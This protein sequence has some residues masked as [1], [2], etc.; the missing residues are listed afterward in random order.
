MVSPNGRIPVFTDSANSLN[1]LHQGGYTRTTRWLDNRYLFVADII[2]KNV[3][4]ISHI[5]GTQ[6]P[7]DGFT[8]P[9]EREAF[10]TFLNLLGMTS[11]T[12][13][14]PQLPGET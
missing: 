14:Q 11:R 2:E 8:K 13:P 10:R 5:A 4:E 3:I 7:A 1:I 12:K 9:L 6:N